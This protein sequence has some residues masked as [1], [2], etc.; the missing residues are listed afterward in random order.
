M[1]S[2]TLEMV[3]ARAPLVF[4]DVQADLAAAVH[5]AVVDPSAKRNLRCHGTGDR[6]VSGLERIAIDYE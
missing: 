1:E 4:E 6:R 2:R 3:S 5:V